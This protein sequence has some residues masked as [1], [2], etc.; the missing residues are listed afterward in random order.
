MEG[1]SDGIGGKLI[2]PKELSLQ[3]IGDVKPYLWAR[4]L[5]GNLG[6]FIGI[7]VRSPVTVA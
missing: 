4:F 5:F 1:K 3:V 7:S 2:T 6:S